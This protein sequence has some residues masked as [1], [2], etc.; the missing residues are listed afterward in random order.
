MIRKSIGLA[1][2]LLL[3]LI[4]PSSGRADGLSYGAWL[5]YWEMD[6]SLDEASRL[7]GQIDTYIAF[8]AYFDSNDRVYVDSETHVLLSV[9]S[10]PTFQ[11]ADVFVSVVNDTQTASGEYDHKSESLLRRLFKSPES[12]SNH[13]EQLITLVD[14]YEPDG[15]ELDYENLGSDTALW[16]SY[17]GLIEDVWSICQREG[18]RLRVVVQWDAP[19]YATLPKG[20]EYSVMCYNLFGNHSG[21]GPKADIDFI[22][23]ICKLFLNVP[24]PVRMAFATGG[25]DWAGDDITALTQEQAI[26][27]L[28]FAGAEPVRD[29]YSGVMKASYQ[30]SGLTH[31]LWYADGQTLAIWRDICIEYGYDAYDLFRLGGNDLKDWSDTLFKT[32]P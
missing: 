30:D 22:K 14:I 19:L 5:P 13:I 8:A 15:L 28:S 9:L 21:P 29:V 1:L 7:L 10:E 4:Y 31:E 27:Q 17:T 25:F 26:E 24:G 16:S 32:R 11:N 18:I 6:A 3:G 20:P 12:R 23:E 2:I